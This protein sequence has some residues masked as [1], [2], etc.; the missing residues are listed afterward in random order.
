M[1]GERIRGIYLLP[2][3]F[4]TCALFAGFYAIIAAN[5]A[6][7]HDAAVAV[8]VAMILDGVDGRVARLTNTQSEFGAE[9]DSFSDLIAFGLAPALVVYHWSLVSL[10]DLGPGWAKLGWLAAFFYTAMTAMRLARFNVQ[11]DDEEVDNRYFSGLPSP[12]AAALVIGFM[13]FTFDNK[14]DGES[15]RWLTFLVV[16]ISGALMMSD[17]KYH[18]FKEIDFMRKVHALWIPAL[19]ICLTALAFYPPA[20]LFL[21]ALIYT[22][23]GPAQILYDKLK[24][25]KG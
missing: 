20:V 24:S 7:F 18:S 16:L 23:S 10:N 3:L 5:D 21:G 4:T 2:N 22:A 6:R 1:S 19:V 12:T 9:Y 13:W 8:L 17:V 25:R 11:H 15:V 14:V